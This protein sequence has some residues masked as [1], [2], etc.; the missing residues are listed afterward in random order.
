MTIE[1]LYILL[2]EEQ[3]FKKPAYNATMQ[4]YTGKTYS[5]GRSENLKNN[6]ID[7]SS[8]IEDIN[9]IQPRLD[10]LFRK[11]SFHFQNTAQLN[12]Q[13]AI[14]DSTILFRGHKTV[15][16]FIKDVDTKT[17]DDKVY[18]AKQPLNAISFLLM[19]NTGGTRGRSYSTPL[20]QIYGNKI[21]YLTI[22]KAKNNIQWYKDFGVERAQQGMKDQTMN[23]NTGYR[24][25]ETA[26]IS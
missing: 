4:D 22:A 17:Q 12:S 11:Y 6:E 25:A 16:P 19:S 24:R 20:H 23:A 2:N 9:Q 5:V 10:D 14:N 18:W 3:Y 7:H 15:D 13:L 26:V 8:R 1:H 21:G